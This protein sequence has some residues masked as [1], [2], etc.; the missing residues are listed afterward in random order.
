[1]LRYFMYSNLVQS[2]LQVSLHFKDDPSVSQSLNK[3]AN[4][5][6]ETIK[7]HSILIDQTTRSVS[8]SLNNF[9]KK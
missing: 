3:V 5:L 2:I 4:T 8:R 1:M 6:Q 9:M 7:Y